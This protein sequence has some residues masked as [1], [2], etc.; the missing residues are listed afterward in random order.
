MNPRALGDLGFQR[1]IA[2]RGT[3][4]RERAPFIS[5]LGNAGFLR[6]EQIRSHPRFQRLLVEIGL[7]ITDLDDERKKLERRLGIT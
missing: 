5:I 2:E 4:H 6:F 7:P 1:R 3:A